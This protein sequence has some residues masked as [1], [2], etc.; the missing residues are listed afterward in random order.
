LPAA[1][2][3]SHKPAA[4]STPNKQQNFFLSF[5][6]NISFEYRTESSTGADPGETAAHTYFD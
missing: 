3:P 1:D 5:T 6:P 4:N 2:T